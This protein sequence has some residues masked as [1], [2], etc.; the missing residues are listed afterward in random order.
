MV[1]RGQ[2]PAKFV[3]HVALPERITVAVLTYIPFL[4]GFHRD[5]LE[6]LRACLGSLWSTADLPYDLLVFDNGSGPEAI[7]FLRQAHAEGKI[8]YL[9]LSEKNLGKG[10]AWNI[11]FPAAPGEILAYTDSDAFFY[12]G[13]L[14]NSVRILETYPKVGMVTSRPFRTPPEFYG[15]TV[16][17]AEGEAEAGLERGCFIPWETFREFDMSL[18]QSEGEIRERYETTQDLKLTYRGLAAF[19][20]A[21]HWQ[22]VARK[23]VLCGFLPFEMDRPMGQ[24]RTLDRLVD[25]AGYL[26]LMTADPLVMNMSNA[27][28]GVPRLGDGGRD[29]RHRR[30]LRQRLLENPP[31]KRLLLAVYSRIFEWYYGD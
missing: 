12:E 21:S 17:W 26:R 4:S 24:V 18:G 1:R 8:Q 2:N 30:G 20:G 31:V 6:V 9:L 29:L 16:A 7:E 10:G 23:S 14:S 22:F 25:E 19:I 3:G 11:I 28:D 27:V 15:S 13:W 5:A